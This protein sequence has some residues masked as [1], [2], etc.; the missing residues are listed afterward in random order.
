MQQKLLNDNDTC[1]RVHRKACLFTVPDHVYILV[2]GASRTMIV[3]FCWCYLQVLLPDCN[4]LPSECVCAQDNQPFLI[5]YHD[6][7]TQRL[8]HLQCCCSFNPVEVELRMLG[9]TPASKFLCQFPSCFDCA[10]IQERA[11]RFHEL[12]CYCSKQGLFSESGLVKWDATVL[13]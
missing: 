12:L 10:L 5:S 2:C 9:Y 13:L 3:I 6:E 7:I 8:N 1:Y 11:A 4:P